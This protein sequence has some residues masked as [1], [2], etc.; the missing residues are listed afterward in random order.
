[1]KSLIRRIAQNGTQYADN[2]VEKRKI[3]HL[4]LGV[5]GGLILFLFNL[6]YEYTLRLPYTLLMDVCFTFVLVLVLY[7]NSKGKYLIGRNLVI[8]SANLLLVVGTI[9]EGKAAANQVVFYPLFFIAAALATARDKNREVFML[10]LVTFCCFMFAMFLAPLHSKIQNIPEDVL[11]GMYVGNHV[12]AIITCI[13]IAFLIVSLFKKNEAELI[14]AKEIA[15]HSAKAKLDFLGNMSHELRTP[16]NGII[17]TTNLMLT[18]N[19][20]SVQGEHLRLLK[21]S[22]NHM[23]NLVNQVLDYSKIDSGK[24]EL[25]PHEFNLLA[26]LKNIKTVFAYQFK[27]KGLELN[28]EYSN[29]TD[30]YVFADDVKL[31]QILNNLLSNALKFTEKGSVKICCNVANAVN[32]EI[33]VNFAVEDTGLGIAPEKQG[34]IFD[35]FEQADGGKTTRKFGGTGLGLSISKQLVEAFGGDI[36]LQSQLNVGS[37]FSFEISL[38][39]STEVKKVK[40]V[41]QQKEEKEESFSFNNKTVLIADDNKVNLLIAKKFLQSWGA[42]V[43]EAENGLQAIDLAA[44]NSV[45]LLLLD[46]EMPEADGYVA[47]NQIRKQNPYLPAIAFTAAYF[48]DIEQKLK[49]KGFNDFVLKPFKPVELNQ[50][51]AALMPE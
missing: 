23:L 19:H 5:F 17:G 40:S 49:G 31:S 35:V 42:L 43:I 6:A 18:E 14:D 11:H 45:D 29:N 51:L 4:N 16:L 15:E 7:I 30:V 26:F 48:S 1:V 13:I 2:P 47:L 20:N 32:N 12:I 38:Q 44:T 8:I 21:Y 36:I 3:S 25:T 37:K 22:S 27:Q 10:F 9:V 41:T 50:K 39:L 28:L 46:L 34:R 33:K 24:I